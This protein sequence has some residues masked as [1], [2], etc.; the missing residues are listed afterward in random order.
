MEMKNQKKM[1]SI[2]MMAEPEP[3]VLKEIKLK[4]Q[5]KNAKAT[6]DKKYKKLMKQMK[7]AKAEDVNQFI[8]TKIKGVLFVLMAKTDKPIRSGKR[9]AF[10]FYDAVIMLMNHVKYFKASVAIIT[11]KYL[12]DELDGYKRAFE[13]SQ[14]IELDDI[15]YDEDERKAIIEKQKKIEYQYRFVC[16]LYQSFLEALKI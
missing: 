5:A 3:S 2:V 9:I 6:I 13:L 8:L 11:A 15:H 14:Q 10:E 7:D 16:S 4:A 12:Q 1:N